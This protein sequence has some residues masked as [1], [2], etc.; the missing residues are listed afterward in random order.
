MLFQN[1]S[2]LLR[3]YRTL[4][5]FFLPLSM[6]KKF[7][8]LH[9]SALRERV[10]TL[11]AYSSQVIYVSGMLFIWRKRRFKLIY[12]WLRNQYVKLFFKSWFYEY[13][14]EIEYSKVYTC[15]GYKDDIFKVWAIQYFHQSFWSNVKNLIT[16]KSWISIWVSIKA[17]FTWYLSTA[18]H[19]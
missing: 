11:L 5:L 4:K 19:I 13:I 3:K 1:V 6:K 17:S 10:H 16:N 7:S 9:S 18:L 8:E 12:K 15:I 14:Y 2:S